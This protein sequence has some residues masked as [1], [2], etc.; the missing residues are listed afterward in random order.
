[1]KYVT[2]SLLIKAHK[3]IIMKNCLERNS[4][5]DYLSGA[6]NAQNCTVK[7]EAPLGTTNGNI[8]Q[9]FLVLSMLI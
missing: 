2:S 5:L 4:G 8:H 3:T 7:L 1:M 6:K 9:V